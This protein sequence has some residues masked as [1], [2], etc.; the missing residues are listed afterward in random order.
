[1]VIWGHSQGGHAA[2]WAG[3]IASTWAPELH[4]L[5]TVAGAPPSQLQFVYSALQNSP[6]RYYLLMAAAGINAAYPQA[7][8]DQVLTPLALSKLGVVDTA[9]G[10]DIGTPYAGLPTS[11]L[12]KVDPYS[13]E[14]WRSLIQAQEPGT[15]KTDNPIVIIQGGSD[16]QIPV[17]SSALLENRMCGL[18]QVVSRRIY[19]G[20]SHAGV[21]PVADPEMQTWIHD[22]FLGLPAPDDCAPTKFL[23]V[24]AQDLLGHA[25]PAAS[26]AKDL[27]LL[28]SP[29]SQ[30]LKGPVLTQLATSPGRGQERGGPRLRG[31]PRP[32]GERKWCRVLGQ[33]D[34]DGPAHDQLRDRQAGGQPRRLRVRVKAGPALADAALITAWYQ[35]LLG[36][37]PNPTEISRLARP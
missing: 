17:A 31:H 10:G 2:L 12:I 24:A 29:T 35:K 6:F 1:M 4:V 37:A 18:G 19:T 9:C 36:R 3:Q 25:L 20:Q 16:E 7:K 26:T 14:P 23:S 22:R 11:A 15:V 34:R 28:G 33:P 5:G 21:I 13:I 32:S 27:K 30:A 8:L